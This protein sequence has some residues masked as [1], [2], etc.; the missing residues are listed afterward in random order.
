MEPAYNVGNSSLNAS[1]NSSARQPDYDRGIVLSADSMQLYKG[2]DVITN[3][4]TPAEMRGVEHWGLD[5][6]QPGQGGSWELGRWC[7]EAD[8]VV[9]PFVYRFSLISYLYISGPHLILMNR[10]TVYRLR[11]YL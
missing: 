1:S 7:T 11:H 2:L 9:G 3:K 10:L 5:V 6:V 4:A 8:K